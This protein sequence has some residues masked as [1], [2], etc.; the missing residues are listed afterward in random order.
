MGQLYLSSIRSPL[1]SGFTSHLGVLRRWHNTYLARHVCKPTCCCTMWTRS[2]TSVSTHVLIPLPQFS[3]IHPL[4]C[5]ISHVP[6]LDTITPLVG[7]HQVMGLVD[8]MQCWRSDGIRARRVGQ[9]S[10]NMHHCREDDLCQMTCVANTRKLQRRISLD[11]CNDSQK[12][13]LV[14]R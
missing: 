7:S 2:S 11:D 8:E 14:N 12:D 13:L 10:L 9:R 1:Y 3:I 5:C 6:P 4:N